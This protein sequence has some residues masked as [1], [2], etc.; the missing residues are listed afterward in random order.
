MAKSFFNWLLRIAYWLLLKLK[1]EGRESVPE[2]G[3][4][5]FMINHIH[6]LDPFVVL[7]SVPRK[8]TSLSKEENMHIPFWGLIFKLY[9]TIPVRRGEVDRQALKETLRVLK[10]GEALL[11]APEGTRSPDHALQEAHNGLAFIAH[12][13]RAAIV[14]VAITGTPDFNHNVKRLRRTPVHIQLGNPFYVQ[15]P[16]RRLS[17]EVLQGMTTEAMYQLAALL[18]SEHRGF[19]SELDQATERYIVFVDEESDLPALQG[20]D[21]SKPNL[22]RQAEARER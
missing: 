20:A 10:A 18:P 7:A 15:A 9:G 5:I 3:P 8:V 6:F 17:R 13:S 2:Q 14:P 21:D 1:V 12:H 11:I 19:Y 16:A 4:V 22:A